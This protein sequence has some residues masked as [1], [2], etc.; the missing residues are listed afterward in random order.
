VEHSVA[1]SIPFVA[2]LEEVAFVGVLV[3]MVDTTLA[4]GARAVH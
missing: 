3:A 1:A 4:R 2:I